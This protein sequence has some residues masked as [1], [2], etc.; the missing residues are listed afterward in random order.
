[1]EVQLWNLNRSLMKSLY[2]RSDQLILRASGV[3]LIL[4][5]W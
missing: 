5:S 1:M 3:L 4:V 2:L